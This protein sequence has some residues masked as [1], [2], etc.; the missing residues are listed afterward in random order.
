[1]LEKI[2]GES[3]KKNNF[4]RYFPK[5]F[6]KLLKRAILFNSIT[7]SFYV[8]IGKFSGTLDRGYTPAI[9]SMLI[10]KIETLKKVWN[11]FEV[12]N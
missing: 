11:M 2:F 7:L 9:T 12:N 3:E 1:M 4:N 6:L 8:R 10:S 5:T